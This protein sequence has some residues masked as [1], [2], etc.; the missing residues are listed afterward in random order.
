M[1]A[2][3]T[4]E[5]ANCNKDVVREHW[6]CLTCDASNEARAGASTFVVA[7]LHEPF[8]P[9]TVDRPFVSAEPVL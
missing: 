5:N 3:A 4:E 7:R 1:Y 2:G 9:F 8:K 6:L